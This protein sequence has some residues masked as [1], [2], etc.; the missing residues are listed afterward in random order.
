MSEGITIDHDGP[1]VMGLTMS[2]LK[3]AI[4]Y[5]DLHHPHTTTLPNDEQHAYALNGH[6]MC[7]KCFLEAETPHVHN[8]E[9][10]NR[11][12]DH[13]FAIPHSCNGL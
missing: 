11:I 9:C 7:D 10:C 6:S 3:H 4:A 13:R 5:H 1:R 8:S 2:E 12:D